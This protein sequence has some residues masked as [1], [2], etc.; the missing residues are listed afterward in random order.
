MCRFLLVLVAIILPIAKAKAYK[1]A[2]PRTYQSLSADGLFVFVMISPES[3]SEEVRHFRDDIQVEIRAIRSKF[4]KA[5]MYRNDGSQEPLWTVDWYAYQVDVPAGG[6]HVIRYNSGG[7]YWMNHPQL[8]FYRRAE[9][10]RAYEMSDLVA[11]TVYLNHGGW[12][13]SATLDDQTH[14]VAVTTKTFDRY[15][16][17]VHTGEMTSRYR[18]LVYAFRLLL[19]LAI[20]LPVWLVRRRRR[21]IALAS[22]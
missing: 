3:L 16:F 6:E 2:T 15:T 10:I 9:L 18:P 20:L 8:A 19:L 22:R 13:A 11:T 7:W 12:L 14:T 5:G 17:D 1:P 4:S 21:R